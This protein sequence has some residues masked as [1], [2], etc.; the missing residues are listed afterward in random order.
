MCLQDRETPGS[1]SMVVREV[2][3]ALGRHAVSP[4]LRVQHIS[5]RQISSWDQVQ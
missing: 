4:A 3:V 2:G 5:K 1:W